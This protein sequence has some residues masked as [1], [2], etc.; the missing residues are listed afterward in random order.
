MLD[1]PIRVKVTVKLFTSAVAAPVEETD[2]N[3]GGK[4]ATPPAT[5]PAIAAVLLLLRLGAG[6][7]TMTRTA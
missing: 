7:S 2:E 3:D 6:D 1:Y 5:P 4:A